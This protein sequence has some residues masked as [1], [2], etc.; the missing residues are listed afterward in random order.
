MFL[1]TSYLKLVEAVLLRDTYQESQPEPQL[2]RLLKGL[3]VKM[4]TIRRQVLHLPMDEIDV[5]V[6]S[7]CVAVVSWTMRILSEY[8]VFFNTAYNDPYNIRMMLDLLADAMVAYTR[9]ICFTDIVCVTTSEMRSLLQRMPPQLPDHALRSINIIRETKL[10][11]EAASDKHGFVHRQLERQGTDH[12]EATML[13]SMIGTIWI[14]EPT[15]VQTAQGAPGT[16]STPV[17]RPTQS[18]AEPEEAQAEQRRPS[19]VVAPGGERGRR[20]STTVLNGMPAT[21]RQRRRT[22]TVESGT[23]RKPRRWSLVSLASDD[24]STDTDEQ[25]LRKTREFAVAVKRAYLRHRA[26]DLSNSLF[27]TSSTASLR[28]RESAR[29]VATPVTG[30]RE[31]VTA[32]DRVVVGSVVQLSDHLLDIASHEEDSDSDLERNTDEK[33]RLRPEKIAQYTPFDSASSAETPGASPLRHMQK[34][35]SASQRFVQVLCA[36]ESAFM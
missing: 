35:S 12:D 3:C 6:R 20:R 31:H 5:E 15:R 24:A 23:Q 7:F 21:P 1:Q 19:V 36:V 32:Q 29:R 4:A 11:F 8:V 9:E 22:S 17:I 30:T 13:A 10:E 16:P 34:L 18:A 25:A 26:G 14:L 27:S 28:Q 33:N 2:L